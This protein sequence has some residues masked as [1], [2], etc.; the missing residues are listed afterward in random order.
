MNTRR[1]FSWFEEYNEED[2]ARSGNIATETVTLDAGPLKDFAHSLEPRLRSL[3]MPTSLQKGVVILLRDFEI[4][5]EGTPLT[6]EQASILVM[7]VLPIALSIKNQCIFY[8]SSVQKLLD[9]KMAQ[10]KLTI[11]AVWESD[12]YFEEYLPLVKTEHE[13]ST[14]MTKTRKGKKNKFK[15]EQMSAEEEEEEEMSEEEGDSDQ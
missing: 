1:T 6:P 7:T 13:G 2:Y 11:E 3:G 14:R 5:K 8:L 9:F 10:F 4:C 12:G 15:Q